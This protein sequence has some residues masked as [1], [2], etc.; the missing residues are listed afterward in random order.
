LPEIEP[1]YRHLDFVASSGGIMKIEVASRHI[2]NGIQDDADHCAIARAIQEAFELDALEVEVNCEDVRI[3]KKVFELPIEAQAFI[4][5]FD[6][7][8]SKARP[9]SFDL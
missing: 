4:K 8:K 6:R 7:A 1:F 9:F 2:K 3:G 5:I